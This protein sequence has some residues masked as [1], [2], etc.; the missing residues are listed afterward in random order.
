MNKPTNYSHVIVASCFSIQAIGIGV[1]VSYG[2]F[3]NSLIAEFGWPRALISGASS[4][5]FFISGLFAIYIGK[6]NDTIGPKII[7][8]ITGVFFGAGLML[9]SYLNSLWQLYLF[10]GL[11]FGFG[12]SSID[13]IALTTIARWFPLRRGIMTGIA[14]VGTGAGQLSF[15]LLASILIAAYGW[16]N[17]YL[18]LGIAS[19][20]MLFGIAQLLKKDPDDRPDNIVTDKKEQPGPGRALPDLSFSEASKT[21]QLWIVCIVNMTVV[22][23]LMSILVHI[24][25]YGRDIGISAHKAAGVLS[26]IGGVSMAGRFVTGLVIDRIGSKRSMMISFIILITG[27]S[28]LQQA[29]VLWKLYVFACIYGFA[30]GGIFTVVSPIVAE[31]FGTRSHGALFGMVVFFGTAGGAVGPI[32]TGYLFDISGSYSLP[33]LILLLTSALGL[34]IL[35]I[36]R[37]S[38][39]TGSD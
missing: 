37:P 3:F 30:H 31:L 29:D 24:V 6:L 5:A 38:K 36:L 11:I 19:L 33:F 12:L 22:Y 28:W 18:I 7:M 16:R 32:T 34:A 23:C 35:L 9:M 17:A 25:P 13:V 21:L 4:V 15:T 14:K 10:F 39:R 26:T 27:L 8:M 1:Y 2:V 20:V